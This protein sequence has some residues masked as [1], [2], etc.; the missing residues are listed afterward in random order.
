MEPVKPH[1]YLYRPFRIL[2]FESDELI[3]LLMGFIFALVV[4]IWAL[5]LFIGLCVVVRKTKKKMPRGFVKHLLYYA[6]YHHFAGAPSA[7]Q[8]IFQE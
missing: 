6:G 8:R 2:W 4:T 5:F 1:R 3:L 7:F